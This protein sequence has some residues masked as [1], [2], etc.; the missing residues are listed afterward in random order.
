MDF[1]EKTPQNNFSHQSVENNYFFTSV[2]SCNNSVGAL[3][4]PIKSQKMAKSIG[5]HIASLEREN[6]TVKYPATA[7]GYHKSV[8]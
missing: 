2:H 6:A 3:L 8:S 4:K 5:S 1:C 7:L